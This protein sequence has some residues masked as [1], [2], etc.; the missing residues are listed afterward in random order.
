[1]KR[2]LPATVTFFIGRDNRTQVQLVYYITD[3]QSQVPFGKPIAQ[4]WRQQKQLI[5]IVWFE[6]FHGTHYSA[7]QKLV[8]GQI[9]VSP[10]DS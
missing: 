4:G 10:T 2:R 6:D 1:M 7:H 3:K 9:G 5:R 8:D